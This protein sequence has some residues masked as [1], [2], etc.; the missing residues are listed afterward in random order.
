VSALLLLSGGLDSAAV[1]KLYRPGAALFID[2]GQ[3]P[4]RGEERAAR[5]VSRFFGLELHEVAVDLDQFGSGLLSRSREQLSVAPSPEWFPFRNQFLVTLAAATAVRLGYSEVWL[6]LVADD[7]GRHAD[8]QPSFVETMNALLLMQE[9]GLRLRA[10]A[11]DA[12]SAA[13]FEAAGLPDWLVHRTVSCHVSAL[14]CGECPGC[15]KRPGRAT[16][17]ST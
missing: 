14:P 12:A 6:G 10:P 11:H 4:A 16:A 2:Y 7:A 3:R 5:D 8:G 17:Q 9:G 13:V 15:N 1:A